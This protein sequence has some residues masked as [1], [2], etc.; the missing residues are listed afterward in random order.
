VWDLKNGAVKTRGHG[1]G[2]TVMAESTKCAPMDVGFD[3]CAIQSLRSQPF[4]AQRQL[5]ATALASPFLAKK[6][7]P[8]V[9]E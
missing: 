1:R 5:F 8:E 9:C 6:T 2:L 7:Y 4:P 3:L